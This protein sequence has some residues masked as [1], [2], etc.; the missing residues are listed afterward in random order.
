MNNERLKQA[1]QL[2]IEGQLKDAETLYQ[3]ILQENP[4]QSDVLH[5]LAV[6]YAQTGKY[7]DALVALDKAITL[8]PHIVA[9]YN[10]KGNVFLRLNNHEAAAKQYQKAIDLD[11]Q[12]APAY[13]NLGKTYYEQEKLDQAKE[14]YGKAITLNANY[15]DAYFN[16][17]I[18]LAK[19][20][21]NG[22]A[23]DALKHT[24]QLT[25][26]RATAFGQ[27]AEVYRTDGNYQ[28][29][30]ENYNKRIELQPE[31]T[32][33]YHVLGQTYL[34]NQQPEE[35]IIA[36][37]QTLAFQPK[38]PECN[39]D[40]GN[41]HLQS[42]D[43]S[44]ALNYYFRQLEIE[45]MSETYYNIGVIFMHQNRH[46]ESAQYL[47]HAARMDPDYLPV[48]INLGALFLKINRYPDAIKHYQEA[49]RIK[50]DDA[51]IQHILTAIS[52]GEAPEKA[53]TEYL[54]HLFDQY[55][56]YYDKH[57]TEH[58]HYQ[59]HKLLFETIREESDDDNPE[60][61][62][63]DLGCGTGLCGELFKPFAKRLIG[64]DISE[65]MIA[66]AKEKNLYDEL[67]VQEVEDALD[68]FKDNDFIV[69]GDVFSYIGKLDEIFK[70]AKAALKPNGLFAF[71]VEK[72]DTE[73]YELQQT[74]R[75]AH[76][77]TYLES[78]IKANTF[79]TLRFDTIELRK[80][81]NVPVE[82]YLIVLSP[83]SPIIHSSR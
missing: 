45:P 1:Q 77:K 38:H 52:K 51:E 80:Q 35:A 26:K 82:G 24:I 69:A 79:Q 16:L 20:G 29:A 31:H 25:P 61:T 58:L 56:K 78:L 34:Q 83:A 22:Q 68:T 81:K 73:P 3:E 60:W 76:S 75:Y 43:P 50:P 28:K 63:L 19:L 71:T 46:K 4:D 53:P 40:I 15:A 62:I 17:G 23:I 10:S 65:N 70:K 33:T 5:A 55:A 54:Q 21:E 9:L 44:K 37:E 11:A 74:I 36:F 48:H 18:L 13:N 32:E 12:Y 14:Y 8:E 67:K 7:D 27:L 49:L 64:I 72:T 2:H 30:I 39:Q 41:A 47:E 42:G 6:L 66:A 57:L 59:A